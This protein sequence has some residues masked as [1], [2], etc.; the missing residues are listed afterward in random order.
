MIK[1]YYD[2]IADDYE[3]IVIREDEDGHFPYD[4]YQE[5]LRAVA[6]EMTMSARHQKATPAILDLGIGTGYLYTFYAPEQCDLTGIDVSPAMLGKA[7]N[8]IPQGRFFECDVN[9]GFPDAVQDERYDAIV[10]TY[11]S[12]HI[13]HTH[14]MRLIERALPL[15]KPFG[16]LMIAGPIFYD[17]TTKKEFQRRYYGEPGASLYFHVYES[18][19]SEA[20]QHLSLS[21]LRIK[22]HAGIILVEKSYEYALQ[23]EESLIE[24]NRNTMKWKSSQSRKKESGRKVKARQNDG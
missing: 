23:M 20:P 7:R 1:R 15:L 16:K 17:Y 6:E 12:E 22:P 21:F 5:I 11:M 3:K 9:L 14:L 19:V 18:I 10:S 13:N 8:R 24:Y 2:S 4:G